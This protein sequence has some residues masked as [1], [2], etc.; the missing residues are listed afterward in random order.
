M[1]H[2]STYALCV[3]I[4]AAVVLFGRRRR[5]SLPLPPGP[6]RHP[7]LG[8]ARDVPETD[9]WIA[10]ARLGKLYGTIHPPSA[11]T[12]PT[13]ERPRGPVVHLRVLTQR[14]I[15]LN[16]LDA[17]TELLDRRGGMYSDRPPFLMLCGLMGWGWVPSL[18]PYDESWRAHRRVIH[19][20]FHE[21]AS[22][23]YRELQTKQ[24]LAFMQALLQ[25]PVDFAE[26]IRHW[27]GASI[28]SL[29]YGID[30]ARKGDPWVELVD[31]AFEVMTTAGL[32]GRYAV[33]WLPLLRHVP[34]WFPGAGFQ[35]LA[36]K[37]RLLADRVR[38]APLEEVKEQIRAG[39]SGNSIAA[40]LL[41][42][43]LEGR[44]LSEELIANA[45]GV[46]YLGGAETTVAVINA[47]IMCM[48]LHPDKQ[49]KAQEEIDRVLGHGRLPEFGDRT[50]LPYV[51]SVL[52][53]VYRLYPVLPSAIPRRVMEDDEYQG[54]RIPKGAMVIPNAWSIL[55]DAR[56]YPKP[57][58]FLPERYIKNGSLALKEMTD[59]R[60]PL[61]GFGRRICPGRH[62]ADASAWL[63]TASILACFNIRPAKDQDGNDLLPDGELR[64]GL[65]TCPRPFKCDITPRSDEATRLL[66]T[67][68][69]AL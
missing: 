57:E 13:D 51:E 6:P 8:N 20:F 34:E 33:D 41:Q 31:S 69:D 45:V 2:A 28:M 56:L 68:A 62:F 52:L 4:G 10:F 1:V 49:K 59:P 14:I 5:H 61:F 19:H 24:N 22:K 65:V 36:R 47:F 25:S 16:S 50:A 18:V 3:L 9:Q 23:G 11:W 53:E 63:A 60:G 42:N 66:A 35:R 38:Y 21:G 43:G 54:M 67:M 39:K 12:S 44:P 26:H 27:T 30:I 58:E 55:R 17:V 46:I 48:I 32:P 64:N 29:A 7:I 37:S 15:V 40:S